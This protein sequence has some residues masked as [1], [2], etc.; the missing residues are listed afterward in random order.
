MSADSH[1]ADEPMHRRQILAV[2]L[3]IALTGLDGYDVLAISF[4]A[5]GIA[6]EW[7]INKAV[8]GV[9]LSIELFGMAAGSALLGTIADRIGRKP[10]ILA[11]LCVMTAGMFAA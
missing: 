9:V 6:A 10:T 4:A 1:T 5:P 8:L 7:G 11:C 3:C 2:V